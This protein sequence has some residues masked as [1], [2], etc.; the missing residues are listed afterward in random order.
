MIYINWSTNNNT[1]DQNKRK[2]LKEAQ[3]R[4]EIQA[5]NKFNFPFF[6]FDIIPR[7]GIVIK[8]LQGFGVFHTM[9]LDPN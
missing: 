8:L 5:I 6:R 3:H 2:D 9:G 4:N 1:M 7:I